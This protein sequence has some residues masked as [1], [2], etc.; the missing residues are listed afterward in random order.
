MPVLL[1]L[2]DFGVSSV[3]RFAAP[4]HTPLKCCFPAKIPEERISLEQLPPSAL[5]AVGKRRASAPALQ[6]L[7]PSFDLLECAGLQPALCLHAERGRNLV[8]DFGVSSVERYAAPWFSVVK[9]DFYIDEVIGA[10]V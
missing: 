10:G 1:R 8:T 3:E 4:C 7:R 6:R 5:R 9:S 2:S